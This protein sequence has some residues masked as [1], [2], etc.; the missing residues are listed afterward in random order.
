MT[1]TRCSAATPE[2]IAQTPGIGEK[3]ARTISE[4]LDDE[5]MRA[6]I[7]DLRGL[8]LQL[9][10]QGPPPSEGLLADKTLVLTGTL[11]H[12]SREQATERIMAAGGRVTG[13][14]SKNTDYLVAGESAGS[15][16]AKA[17]RLARAGARR[18]RV[19]GAVGG[20]AS[21]P[22]CTISHTEGAVAWSPQAL[23]NAL[24]E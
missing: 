19:A 9:R 11:P 15:K 12:W 16:L 14:V 5:R 8:G 10:E 4:Q 13:A 24:S 18:G 3:M 20:V 2:E 7:A 1:S 21:P 6:L 17:E 22:M 23:D